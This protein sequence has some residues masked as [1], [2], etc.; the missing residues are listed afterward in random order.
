MVGVAFLLLFS[1]NSNKKK[2]KQNVRILHVSFGDNKI[3]IQIRN[4]GITA[5]ITVVF[6][7]STLHQ[8][9]FFY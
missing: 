4:V 7:V 5:A 8:D 3:I 9:K 6:N 1:L 2:I